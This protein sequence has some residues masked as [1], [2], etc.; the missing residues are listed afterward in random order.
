M[1]RI[2][3]IVD[4][5]GTVAHNDGH[6][7][8]YDWTKIGEDKPIAGVIKFIKFMYKT[9]IEIIYVSGRMD[10]CSDGTCA[11]IEKHVGSVQ[12]IF[13]RK[14]D[15]YRPDDVVKEEI[16]RDY[17]EPYYDVIGVFDDRTKVVRKWREL[18]L[19]CFQVADGDF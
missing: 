19:T 15:D 10:I 18:G 9:N 3:I 8:P 1:K 12:N 17:I 14:T 11:W 4:I 5:D 6:R 13:M 16:Y 2:A 7:G